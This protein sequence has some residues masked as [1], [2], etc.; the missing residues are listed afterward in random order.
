MRFSGILIYLI[1]VI[2]SFCSFGK[3][4]SQQTA[5]KFASEITSR[6]SV[7]DH[8]HLPVSETFAISKDDTD[9]FYICNVGKDDG[10]VI[11]S[12]QDN[13][14]MMLG[15]SPNGNYDPQNVPP[16][17]K[18]WLDGY[19]NQL[20][21]ELQKDAHL[22]K[23]TGNIRERKYQEEI[24]KIVRKPVV[25]P[26]L[27][28]IQWDQGSNWFM[29]SGPDWNSMCPQDQRS[30]TGNGHVWAGCVATATAMIM[31][32]HSYPE[33]GRGEHSYYHFTYGTQHAD[34]AATTFNW[35]NMPGNNHQVTMDI[36]KLLYQIGVAVNMNY[37]THSSRAY[38][39][40]AVDGLIDY[41]NYS[42]MAKFV[43]R[44]YYSDAEWK[45]M[46]K[47]QLDNGLAILYRGA[48]STGT[49]AHAFVC[50]GYDDAD[51]FHFNWGWS[52]NCNGYYTLDGLIPGT[53]PHS[54]N[55]GH[56][57]GLDI[58]KPGYNDYAINNI[59]DAFSHFVRPHQFGQSFTTEHAGFLEE[60]RLRLKKSINTTLRI[61]RGEYILPANEI[62][63]Q[64]IQFD[65]P[66]NEFAVIHFD[67]VEPVKLKANTVY[68]FVLDRAS[69]VFEQNTYDGGKLFYNGTF[70]RGSDLH[71]YLCFNGIVPAPENL[72][73][74]NVT[75]NSADLNWDDRSLA[76]AWN[77]EYGPAGFSRGS[78][79]K[80]QTTS[81]P[82][83][84]DNLEENQS[85]DFYVQS[86]CGDEK[87]TWSEAGS[88]SVLTTPPGYNIAFDGRN[89]YIDVGSVGSVQTIEFWVKPATL[90]EGLVRLGDTKSISIKKGSMD[91]V[92][93]TDESVYIN[94]RAGRAL[95]SGKWSH[96]AIVAPSPF[97]ASQ[98][99]IGFDG[100][101]FLHGSIDE[102]RLWSAALSQTDIQSHLHKTLSGN[103]TNL[104]AYYPCDEAS[105]IEVTD[106][107][108]N[109]NHGALLNTTGDEWNDSLIPAG[110]NADWIS[111]GSK[112][113]NNMT[114][115][116]EPGSNGSLG[117]F[118][119]GTGDN[120][121]QTG[122]G[123]LLN[124]YWGIKEY[125]SVT[126]TLKFDLAGIPLP[127]GKSW[128]DIHLLKRDDKASHWQDI[129]GLCSHTPTRSE[130]YF[131]ITQSEFSEFR[132]AMETPIAV[133][134]A[135]FEAT[136]QN[137]SV[138][139]RW[140]TETETNL[141]GFYISRRSDKE[142]HFERINDKLISASGESSRNYVYTDQ[143]PH[144]GKWSYRLEEIDLSGHVIHHAP[145]KVV[146]ASAVVSEQKTPQ[147][148]YLY[149]NHPN[150]FNPATE[151]FFDMSHR[152]HVKIAVY[153][154]LGRHVRTLVDD[155]RPA[156]HHKDRW[157]A[158]DK[159][160]NAVASGVYF[161]IMTA[162]GQRFKNKMMLLH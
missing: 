59:H 85:F 37:G 148:F 2:T 152:T 140:L 67:I 98:L 93:E 133:K 36:A 3:E 72:A 28:E 34:F 53:T 7:F 123:K 81:H 127:S 48:D 132:P 74:Q 19:K 11:M 106:A 77:V 60:I 112:S 32:Y 54:Y 21:N 161:L 9:L 73:K 63:S 78:G 125:G 41:F 149:P 46:I 151:F 139:L 116:F 44:M 90:T 20:L 153:D 75:R 45:N 6:L 33:Q 25:A 102:F 62:Y 47:E 147:D 65:L 109:S 61:Y 99:T 87:S 13:A 124:K 136:R 105:G 12:A 79:T 156:G 58:K 144:D 23:D 8:K 113:L 17:F 89:D 43:I 128:A 130:P 141:A 114:V 155:T 86:I 145:V 71:F 96:V 129:T 10:F 107:S 52:G 15:Y 4:I 104:V 110:D 103:E 95:E 119:T 146:L 31:K 94:G 66:A 30:T 100:I 83:S 39:G 69:L 22:E 27:K 121:L 97:N 64:P 82:Y 150:P 108:Q 68:T 14:R 134:L 18:A 122:D 5:S 142:D 26:L 92:G 131:E 57:A 154:A 38:T 117:L 157:D 84:L 70:Y 29:D 120:W 111:S 35:S 50:D 162:H 91:L 137:E 56:A 1:L 159:Y 49:R 80:V 118:A 160:N 76:T 16:N 55:Y 42:P 24:S 126:A 158:T 88:F 40:Y 115:T 135:Y 143:P 138:C 101:D 51:Y